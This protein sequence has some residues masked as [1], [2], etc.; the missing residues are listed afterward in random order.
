[1][2]AFIEQ[3]GNNQIEEYDG[4]AHHLSFSLNLLGW[5]TSHDGNFRQ[6]FWQR[7]QRLGLLLRPHRG[8]SVDN[9]VRSHQ[10]PKMSSVENASSELV[11]P[12]MALVFTAS[13][14]SGAFD[15]NRG[16]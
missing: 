4:V 16:C 7:R 12:A 1:M 14:K 13:M 2:S 10:E 8:L 15:L 9:A 11:M 6:W 3:Q 5:L